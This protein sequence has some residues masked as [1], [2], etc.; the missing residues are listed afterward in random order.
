MNAIFTRRSVR[1]YQDRPVEAE[2]IDRLL[3]KYY[4][5]TSTG[6]VLSRM[7]NDVDTVGQ[8][9]SASWARCWP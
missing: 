9:W 2:K 4:D 7:T 5:A 6:D 3:L 1:T 8:W